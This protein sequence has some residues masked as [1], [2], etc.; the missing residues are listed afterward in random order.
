[1]NS[2][3]LTIGILGAALLS[4]S[5]AMAAPGDRGDRD[6]RDYGRGDDRR[7]EMSERR[8]ER[9]RSERGR[10]G[11]YEDRVDRR[12]QVQRERIRDGLRDG[13]I[14]RREFKELKKDQR[15]ISR[16]ERRFESDG[17]LSRHE[18]RKLERAQD[19]ASRDI[20]RAKRDDRGNRHGWDRDHH[21]R[22]QPN[23]KRH[24]RP[25]YGYERT[26]APVEEA[27]TTETVYTSS[28]SSSNAL[29]FEMNG[30]RVSYS[31]SKQSSL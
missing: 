30:I 3:T 17:H 11:D 9:G 20:H 10:S 28:E 13:D 6:G 23:W 25:W 29:D 16:M 24:S 5:V 26:A 21:K 7:G 18:K 12:Q 8:A 4:S 14:S 19:R 22:Y 31:R 27:V 1:M 2:K 15:K